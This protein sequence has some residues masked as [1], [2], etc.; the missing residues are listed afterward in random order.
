MGALGF[1]IG[2]EFGITGHLVTDCASWDRWDSRGLHGFGIACG[3]SM[4]I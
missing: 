2:E 3:M 4:I 1:V